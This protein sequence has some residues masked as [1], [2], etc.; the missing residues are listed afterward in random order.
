MLE[1][2]IERK[3]VNAVRKLGGQCPKFVSPGTVG[4]PDRIILLPGGVI[5]F[6]EIKAPGEQPCP[7]QEHRHRQLRELGFTVLVIDHPSQIPDILDTLCKPKRLKKTAKKHEV[8][9]P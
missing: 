7:L 8:P 3:L 1:S 5:A 9:A 4:V 2:F 6:A